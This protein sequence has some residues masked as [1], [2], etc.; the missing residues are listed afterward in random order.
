MDPLPSAVD[1]Q[2]LV[3]EL[4]KS[5]LREETIRHLGQT[6]AP[7]RARVAAMVEL[8]R[9]LVFPGYF[10][11]RG[12][13]PDGL[14]EFVEDLLSRI[15]RHARDQIA[16]CLRYASCLAPDESPPDSPQQCAADA[17][18]LANRFIHTMPEL[19]RLTA[20]DVRAGL[21]VPSP[22]TVKRR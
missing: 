9:H 5:I 6:S 16:S 2:A 1:G 14:P 17:E 20:L 7:D 11:G 12:L 8:C 21:V 19:R 3:R 22:R 18:D 4:A 10:A 13:T 15:A